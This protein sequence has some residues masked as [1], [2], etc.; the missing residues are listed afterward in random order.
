MKRIVLALALL[1]AAPAF[2]DEWKD[3]DYSKL[4]RKIENE[5]KYATKDP[6]YALFVLDPEG[7]FLVWFVMDGDDLYVANK[8]I[9]M[10]KE[11]SFKTWDIGTMKVPGT[12]VAHTE[13]LLRRYNDETGIRF[14]MKW[15][16]KDKVYAGIDPD[17]G[18]RTPWGKSPG[19]APVLRPCPLGPLEFVFSG[20]TT[21]KTGEATKIYLMAGHKGSDEKSFSCVHDVYLQAGKDRIFVTLVA[22][23][24]KGAEVKVK[25]EIKGHC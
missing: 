24:T 14:S 7:K 3:I 4:E 20:K 2:G 17:G 12:E 1:G 8:K 25:T 15:A 13:L 11:P 10:K 19:E 18:P 16:G 22:K 5:P 6:G 21:L 23:D 9:P